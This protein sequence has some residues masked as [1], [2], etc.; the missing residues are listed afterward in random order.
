[1]Q[2]R[3]LNRFFVIW[4]YIARSH[5][6]HGQGA[7][8]SKA[9][10]LFDWM[11]AFLKDWIVS[12]GLSNMHLRLTVDELDLTN[13]QTHPAFNMQ[14]RQTLNDFVD[15]VIEAYEQPRTR[16]TDKEIAS[17]FTHS[18]WGHGIGPVFASWE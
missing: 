17:F 2:R 10:K 15:T 5:N 9:F 13:L 14:T 12:A 11:S 1:M 8:R 4:L 7:V 3:D 6:E 16:M 18:A